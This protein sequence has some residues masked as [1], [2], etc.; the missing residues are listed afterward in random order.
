MITFRGIFHYYNKGETVSLKGIDLEI[1]KGEL[2]L[3]LGKNGSGKTTLLNIIAG[4]LSPTQGEITID[5]MMIQKGEYEKHVK[6]KIVHIPQI[7]RTIAPRR[8]KVKEYLALNDRNAT[9]IQTILKKIGLEDKSDQEMETLSEGELQRIITF[10]L[11]E[12]RTQIVLC[13]EV[14]SFLDGQTAT[15]VASMIQKTVLQTQRTVIIASHDYRLIPFATKIYFMRDGYIE[16]IETVKEATNFDL[17]NPFI[18][19]SPLVRINTEGVFPLPSSIVKDL[20]LPLDA[21]FSCDNSKMEITFPVSSRIPISKA[22]VSQKEESGT[23]RLIIRQLLKKYGQQQVLNLQNVEL[24][25]TINVIYGPSGSGK[26]TLLKILYGVEQADEKHIEFVENGRTIHSPRISYLPQT[27]Y[28]PNGLMV[29]ELM[30]TIV[31]SKKSRLIEL[32]QKIG[33]DR[34]NGKFVSDLSGGQKKKLSVILALGRQSDIYLLDEPTAFVD[35][36]SRN[37]ILEFLQREFFDKMVIIVTHDPFFG[38][39][40]NS[41]ELLHKHLVPISN[42]NH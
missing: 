17:V 27:P 42:A 5:G 18:G 23:K 38:R 33:M 6:G 12:R 3:L 30:E 1:N 7:P 36:A 8:L 24:S 22:K 31:D 10:N 11:L 37:L 15:N 16:K 29:S 41:Y 20:I 40:F 19:I 13:D 2:I 4:N 32:F 25:E 39:H 14:T 35:I 9:D 28:L 26:S 21:T 34:Q